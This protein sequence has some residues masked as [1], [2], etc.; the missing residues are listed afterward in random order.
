MTELTTSFNTIGA[1]ATMMGVPL[2]LVLM[3]IQRHF[4]RG[5]T[6]GAIKD[7]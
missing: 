3:L 4:V 5:L 6:A 7:V 2:L 1:A